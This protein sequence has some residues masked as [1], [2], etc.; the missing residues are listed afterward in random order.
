MRG[1]KEGGRS[2]RVD[3]EGNVQHDLSPDFHAEGFSS[4]GKMIVNLFKG[5]VLLTLVYLF[6]FL[7]HYLF[8]LNILSIY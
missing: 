4:E 2:R 8:V 5:T 7:T 1:T 6:A 3:C